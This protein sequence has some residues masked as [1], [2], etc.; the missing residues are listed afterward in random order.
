MHIVLG[1]GRNVEIENMAHSGNIETASGNVGIV[2]ADVPPMLTWER[3]A[4]L[5]ESRDREAALYAM[6]SRNRIQGSSSR[7]PV[8][9]RVE[10]VYC[11]HTPT[12]S[13]VC[14][15]NVYYIDTG[16]VYVQ[17][18]YEDA[19]LTVVE[20]HPERHVEHEIRTSDSV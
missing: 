7:L 11:G 6:W 14:L 12:R 17:E 5:L 1:M 2:H 16:A 13:T 8:K 18:G 10:R 3:F 15:Q 20:I 9:G 19:R 4:D